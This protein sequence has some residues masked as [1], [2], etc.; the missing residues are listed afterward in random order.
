MVKGMFRSHISNERQL[1][2]QSCHERQFQNLHVTNP[3]QIPTNVGR[4]LNLV[5][6]LF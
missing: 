1:P 6:I 5:P 4:D 3:C 2:S